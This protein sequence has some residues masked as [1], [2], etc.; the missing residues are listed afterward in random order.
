MDCMIMLRCAP[1]LR[2][3]CASNSKATWRNT[4]QQIPAPENGNGGVI[5][6]SDPAAAP[7]EGFVLAKKKGDGND[8]EA[9]MAGGNKKAKGS[10][11]GRTGDKKPDKVGSI[12]LNA[13]SCDVCRVMFYK[14]RFAAWILT[15]D[16]AT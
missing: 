14:L 11:K 13:L 5:T 9:W 8:I 6:A 10:K 4:R 1:C 2:L 16:V 12:M 3:L 7:P 15:E